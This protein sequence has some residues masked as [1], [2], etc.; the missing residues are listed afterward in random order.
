[1]EV[2]SVKG[3][4]GPWQ[5]SWTWTWTLMKSHPR[6]TY[7]HKILLKWRIVL[8]LWIFWPFTINVL[9]GSRALSYVSIY[10]M[11][12]MFKRFTFIAKTNLQ[13]HQDPKRSV[14][15]LCFWIN[16][17]EPQ[18]SNLMGHWT[19]QARLKLSQHGAHDCS[20]WFKNFTYEKGGCCLPPST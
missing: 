17:M 15:I 6:P 16:P 18:N 8:H 5:V 20:K 4:F 1:M 13:G 3:C 12:Q 14:E 7:Q 10:S 11:K 2:R 19:T 9:S